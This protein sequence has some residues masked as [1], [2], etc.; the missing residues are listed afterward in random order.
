LIFGKNVT[1]ER[2]LVRDLTSARY[3]ESLL[4]TGIRFNLWHFNYLFQLY[5]AGAPDQPGNFSSHVGNGFPG[6]YP[7]KNEAQS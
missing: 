6:F 7:D 3:L 5:P 4:G 2:F 1:F